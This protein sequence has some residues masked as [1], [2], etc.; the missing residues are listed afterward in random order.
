MP[1][2]RGNEL[3]ALKKLNASE[4]GLLQ[5]GAIDKDLEKIAAL[6][7]RAFEIGATEIGPAKIGV[8]EVGAGIGG[9]A[10]AG[11]P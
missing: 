9:G 2:A 3:W 7:V 5:V 11:A 6:K 8:L 10:R 1:V 4:I